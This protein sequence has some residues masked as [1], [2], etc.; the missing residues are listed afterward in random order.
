M[1]G[2]GPALA[3]QPVDWQMG[4]QPAATEIMSQ[5]RSFEAYTLWFII[6]ITL[7]VLALLVYVMVKFRAGANPVPSRTSHNSLIEVIWTLGPVVILLALAIPSFNL[8][9][10]QYSPPQADITVKATG[11][12]WY[13]GYEYQ[14]DNELS[15]DSIMLKDDER[16][17]YAK[18]DVAAYPRLLAVD[19][20]LVVPVGQTV[21]LLVT[22]ADVLHSFA[23]PAFGVKMDA[24]PGRLNETWFKA[25]AEGLY[26]GQCS[27]LCGKDH[28]F[29]PIAIRVVDQAK[30]DTWMAEAADDVEAANRN[31]MAAVE[32]D[33]KSVA[34]AANE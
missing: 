1:L 34:V 23:M 17:G 7:L 9:T 28:A 10:A 3:A 15:F 25:E 20:E 33:S 31:L 14:T 8:L 24:V 29:M 13:W 26:Y 5:V 4:F 27:E 30:F 2:A 11:Y 21:R 22:A 19:N 12:Q 6:P 16:A 18:E 32:T